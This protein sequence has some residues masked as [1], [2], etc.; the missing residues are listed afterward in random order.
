MPALPDEGTLLIL[1]GM[2][3]PLYSTRGATQT[4]E[5]IEGAR[6]TARTINGELIDLTIGPEFQKFRSTIS[7]TDDRPPRHLWPGQVVT[8]YCVCDLVYP[9]AGIAP[10]TAAPGSLRTEGDFNIIRPVLEMMLMNNPA[11]FAEYEAD[12]SWTLEFEEV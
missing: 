2:G 12:H 11:S 10:R 7:C 8:V 4:L 1:D 5:P 6:Q 9:S 3:V